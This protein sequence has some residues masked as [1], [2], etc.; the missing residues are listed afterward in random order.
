MFYASET[1]FPS[2]NQVQLEGTK[3]IWLNVVLGYPPSVQLYELCSRTLAMHG[4][5]L[6][7]KAVAA[8]MHE[9]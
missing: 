7:I 2:P 9:G 5:Q 3:T 1:S 4:T 6:V 8:M